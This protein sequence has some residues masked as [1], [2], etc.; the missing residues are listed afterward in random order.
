MTLWG[1][2]IA[3]TIAQAS[4]SE[5]GLSFHKKTITDTVFFFFFFPFFHKFMDLNEGSHSYLS[6]Y[7]KNLLFSDIHKLHKFKETL[8]KS[9]PP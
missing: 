6:S 9:N 8:L 7:E 5:I 4:V 3:S 1:F 2:I